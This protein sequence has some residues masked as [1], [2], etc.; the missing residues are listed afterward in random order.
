DAYIP[1]LSSKKKSSPKK[2]TSQK[3][4]GTIIDSQ[5]RKIILAMFNDPE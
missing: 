5:I 3:K 2:Y 1:K 4:S